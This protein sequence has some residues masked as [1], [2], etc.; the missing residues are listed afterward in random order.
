[1]PTQSTDAPSSS[2][3]A[4]HVPPSVVK[5]MLAETLGVKAQVVDIPADKA[6]LDSSTAGEAKVVD[7]IAP[8]IETRKD[9]DVNDVV[10][11]GTR[12]V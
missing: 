9:I 10:S 3:S 6:N 4:V 2:T 7:E 5:P 12:P 1:M 8:G 11:T